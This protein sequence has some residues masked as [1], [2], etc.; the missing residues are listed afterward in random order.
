MRSPL[1]ALAAVLL[2]AT[3]A[4]AGAGEVRSFA[5]KPDLAPS[6]LM[7]GLEFLTP[8]SRA[9]QLDDFENPGLLWVEAGQ[10]LFEEDKVSTSCQSCHAASGDRALRGVAARYPAVDSEDGELLNLAQRINHC[11]EKYQ[12][13]PRLAY[14][15]A[16]LL[17]LTAYVTSLS[18]G[19]SYQP[20]IDGPANSYFER[21]R[22]YFFTR[23]GQLNLACTQCH[24]DNW[25]RM[26]RG[27]R[28][29]QGHGNAYPAYRLEWQTLGSLHRRFRDC[30]V[31]VR[32]QPNDS[33]AAIYVAL[34][35]Y[36]AWRAGNLPLESPG[37]RR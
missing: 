6:V 21:G 12:A 31:G 13:Q 36:L 16:P 11:R 35:L 29:S 14:E 20:V 7:S 19:L 10:A 24:D 4:L 8:E 32:A 30:D 18:R 33:G 5:D 3:S 27:D 37:V 15:S 17:S 26:L 23:R 9:L 34:E 28:I 25:G 2:A 1:C 22:A